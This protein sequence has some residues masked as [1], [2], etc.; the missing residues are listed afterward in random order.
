M[1]LRQFFVRWSQAEDDRAGGGS[2][3]MTPFQR[4]TGDEDFAG[5]KNDLIASRAPAG[6]AARGVADNNLGG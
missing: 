1:E 3:R 5:R 2:E 4:D 6:E